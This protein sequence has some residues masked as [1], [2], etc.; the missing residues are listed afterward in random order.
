MLR[1]RA[2]AA[3]LGLFFLLAG[4]GRV[5]LGSHDGGGD[6]DAGP[7]PVPCGR[8]LCAPGQVCCSES[9][10]I[11]GSPDGACPAIECLPDDCFSNADCPATHYCNWPG[12]GCA[13]DGPGVCTPRPDGAC[14]PE[15]RETCGCDGVTY[16]SPCDAATQGVSVL[17]DGAC[18]TSPSCEAQ[19]AYGE[20]P[21]DAYLGVRWNGTSCE[22]VSGC[23]CAGTDCDSLYTD[24]TSCEADHAGC[25]PGGAC[26]TNG[27]CSMGQYC[28]YE[29]GT[30]ADPSLGE[31]RPIPGEIA[32][33]SE[34]PPVCGCDGSTYACELAAH[35]V[36]V[37]ALHT[38]A[39]AGACAA[40]D[41]FGSGDCAAWFG[42][43]WNGVA[44]EGVG[45]CSCVGADCDRLYMSEAE[46]MTAHAGCERMPG[47]ECGG[48][49]GYVC[50]PDEWCD[51]AEPHYC[52]GADETG[53][54]RPRPDGCPDVVDPACGCDGTVYENSCAANANGYD[55]WADPSTCGAPP[56]AP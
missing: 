33:P 48:F 37:S 42:V 8:V 9:C 52:G 12:G 49:V 5:H 29:L 36:G 11:C 28:H 3:G 39:C 54:C 6:T 21:C 53:T 10:G 51:F 2:R 46:C 30:C 34:A 15:V 32:C 23:V 18:E 17:H 40:M 41:A 20:G 38:G 22:G 27:D 14:P 45:G 31:C 43:K 35:Q 24:T 55:T 26:A 47:G 19:D 50:R 44:C 4:C 13:T 25:T 7:G 56:P 16:T 1:F